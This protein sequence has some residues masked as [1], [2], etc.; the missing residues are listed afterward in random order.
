MKTFISLTILFC[1]I[2]LPVNAQ[3]TD[4]DLNKIRL[5]VKDEVKAEIT[6]SEKRMKEYVDIRFNAIDKRF[7][8]FKDSVNKRFD[9]VDKRID[10]GNNLTYALIALIIF[11][12]GLPAWQNRKDREDKKKIEALTQRLEALE[13]QQTRVNP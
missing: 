5:I 2:T 1:L 7:D 12:I 8:D 10:H 13:Q 11:A 4:D 3:L 6:A 9:G